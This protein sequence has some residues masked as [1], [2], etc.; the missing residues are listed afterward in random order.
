MV[1]Q[2]EELKQFWLLLLPSTRLWVTQ[3]ARSKT[4][5]GLGTCERDVPSQNL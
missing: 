4:E 5:T 2:R 1:H 3:K